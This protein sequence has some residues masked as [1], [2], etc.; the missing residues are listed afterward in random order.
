[1]RPAKHTSSAASRIATAEH[2]S[3]G[4]NGGEGC[5]KSSAAA[6]PSGSG[7]LGAEGQLGL[8]TNFRDGLHVKAIP[9]A[10]HARRIKH[11]FKPR[12]LRARIVAA[13][14]ATQQEVQRS[15]G[16][17]VADVDVSAAPHRQ[18]RTYMVQSS[19]SSDA[20]SFSDA[21]RLSRWRR[22][23]GITSMST[24]FG[25][26]AMICMAEF[27]ANLI[28]ALP[29]AMIKILLWYYQNKSLPTLGHLLSAL[30][31]ASSICIAIAVCV[32][33]RGAHV[34]P[35]IT[36]LAAALG[37]LT[38]SWWEAISRI[39][40][41]ILGCWA[42]CMLA[43]STCWDI[44][45]DLRQVV[46]ASGRLES[47]F[48]PHGLARSFAVASTPGRSTGLAVV[49]E[50]SGGFIAALVICVNVQGL[51]QPQLIRSQ[52]AF[53]IGATYSLLFL[54]NSL[55]PFVGSS[56]LD[57]GGRLACSVVFFG[58]GQCWPV[59]FVLHAL[60]S[61]T[62]GMLLGFGWYAL[63]LE[64]SA[65]ANTAESYPSE[66][67]A[68]P[69]TARGS[70]H[71]VPPGEGS[72]LRF[73]SPPPPRRFREVCVAIQSSVSANSTPAQQSSP[74]T[75][76]LP[77]KSRQ[78]KPQ[79]SAD[80]RIDHRSMD[81]EDGDVAS[82]A[83]HYQS[84]PP[85][86]MARSTKCPSAL[87][88]RR[89]ST[90][91]Q[92][93]LMKTVP[94]CWTFEIEESSAF[95]AD[96]G[97]EEHLSDTGAAPS[98]GSGRQSIESGS[99]CED[100][101]SDSSGELFRC[102]MNGF[103]NYPTSS[104]DP[105][106][107]AGGVNSVAWPT[108]VNASTHRHGSATGMNR[109]SWTS[110]VSGDVNLSRRSRTLSTISEKSSTLERGG[111]SSSLQSGRVVQRWVEHETCSSIHEGAN[112]FGGSPVQART[113]ASED[114]EATMRTNYPGTCTTDVRD[115]LESSLPLSSL[116][117]AATSSGAGNLEQN[118]SQVIDLD[119]AAT[120]QARC[121]QSPSASA[122]QIATLQDRLEQLKRR[123]ER[124][125]EQL[126]SILKRRSQ[127]LF[128]S[129]SSSSSRKQGIPY[130]RP[131]FDASTTSPASS[132]GR[133]AVLLTGA[134]IEEQSPRRA[135]QKRDAGLV[136]RG[137][138]SDKDWLEALRSH[139]FAD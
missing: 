71:D 9:A 22:S 83:L 56:A 53:V 13:E 96:V 43:V 111:S 117:M 19:F 68:R 46:R 98:L 135:Q 45:A 57:I 100:D 28:I 80:I 29:A 127:E 137:R 37:A 77:E 85:P 3:K 63:F 7:S 128:G 2:S 97:S 129:S 70:C 27:T 26:V 48:V 107:H 8:T 58:A 64:P 40:A 74:Q 23:W 31:Y 99:E 114:F 122:E 125:Q 42:G 81:K 18:K 59:R 12:F 110:D 17:G 60:L 119:C 131:G 90:E 61:P 72:P 47:F 103:P 6:S 89:G 94:P 104:A 39:T 138:T 118:G 91:T 75:A 36:I 4:K 14:S 115:A 130:I 139:G 35:C 120:H 126:D 21:S 88:D 92:C 73:G 102:G 44:I 25:R 20:R 5:S 84:S 50:A 87:Q 54:M 121:G 41:Q 55:G 109:S 106:T 65:R 66:R 112:L 78:N 101:D 10:A 15:S 108:V 62:L 33:S 113:A 67:S 93:A 30:T 82:A 16:R 136:D 105:Y 34:N 11:P 52:G 86:T 124:E 116:R 51:R 95:P 133:A 1:M 76:A 32:P 132:P 24:A 69:E 134:D 38:C 49:G 123:Q 79:R